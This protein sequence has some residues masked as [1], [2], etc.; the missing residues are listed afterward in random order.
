[1][2]PRITLCVFSENSPGILQRITVLFTRR[3]MNIESLTVSETEKKGISR[4]T[5]VVEAERDTIEKVAKQIRRI[6]E[7]SDVYVCENDELVF[8]EIAFYKVLTKSPKI[9]QEIDDLIRSHDAKIVYAT[10]RHVTIE[11]TGS[12]EDIRALFSLLETYT[13]VGFVRS[14]R[15]ALLKEDRSLI[16]EDKG[17]RSIDSEE[18]SISMI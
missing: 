5:I 13:I 6:I 12:E 9:R 14:G 11:R 2:A 3:R 18:E 7:V 10:D 4:F 8:K 16:D 15:I 1:M 17:V